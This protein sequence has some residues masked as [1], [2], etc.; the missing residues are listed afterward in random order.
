MTHWTNPLYSWHTSVPTHSQFSWLS[1]IYLSQLVTHQGIRKTAIFSSRHL[2]LSVFQPLPLLPGGIQIRKQSREQE[3]RKDDSSGKIWK[4]SANNEGRE[5]GND[6]FS[7]WSLW[8]W[9]PGHPENGGKW[10]RL[11]Y[12]CFLGRFSFFSPLFWIN[13]LNF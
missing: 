1:L 3:L 12:G 11:D 10:K 6:Y 4:R 8:Q 2:L 13:N 5:I 9:G 7:G